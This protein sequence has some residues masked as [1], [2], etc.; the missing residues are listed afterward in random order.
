MNEKAD[1]F[2]QATTG[3]VSLFVLSRVFVVAYRLG[4]PFKT[5]GA[6]TFMCGKS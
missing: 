1:N 5:L 3:F 6:Y 2:V 4:R